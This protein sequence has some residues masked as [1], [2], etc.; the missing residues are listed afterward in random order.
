LFST[1]T[2]EQH[3]ALN[4]Q[5]QT[6]HVNVFTTD[7]FAHYLHIKCLQ[8]DQN[9]MNND[10]QLHFAANRYV[11]CLHLTKEAYVSDII[12][13]QLIKAQIV[14]YLQT[15]K[16]VEIKPDV[17]VQLHFNP[18]ELFKL[19]I[20]LSVERLTTFH[21]IV[22]RDFGCECR[23]FTVDTFLALYKYKCGRYWE[24]IQLLD[25]QFRNSI[26]TN[27]I[28]GITLI[29]PPF[30][31]LMDDDLVSIVGLAMLVHPFRRTDRDTPAHLAHFHSIS[32]MIFWLYLEVQCRLKL[33]WPLT[34]LTGLLDVIRKSHRIQTDLSPRLIFDHLLL[35]FIYRKTLIYVK[36][37][38]PHI[39]NKQRR[40]QRHNCRQ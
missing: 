1:S 15:A 28:C 27:T 19:L 39:K 13:F 11:M 3:A 14:Q 32:L 5:Q 35:T 31:L 8:M 20:Q 7:L 36:S 10:Q 25:E 37:R 12:L 23:I 17:R 29:V 22:L 34:V 38:C 33:T 30:I 2:Y 9:R 24:C 26:S 16:V 4:Q 18:N 40:Y 6:P 21:Q